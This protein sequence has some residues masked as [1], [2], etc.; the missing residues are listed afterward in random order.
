MAISGLQHSSV[1]NVKIRSNS[2]EANTSYLHTIVINKYIVTLFQISK[3]I[4]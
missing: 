4:R 2:R 3:T 1:D